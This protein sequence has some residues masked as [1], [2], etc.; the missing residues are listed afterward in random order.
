MLNTVEIIQTIFLI[1]IAFGVLKFT[2]TISKILRN[3]NPDKK[4]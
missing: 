3:P 2:F 1:A 4:V